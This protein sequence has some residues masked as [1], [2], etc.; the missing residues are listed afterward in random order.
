MTIDLV[1]NDDR[2][3]LALKRLS[4]H[5]TGL[6]QR[7]FRSIDQQ[8]HAVH[9]GQR[10]LHFP[11]KVS[12]AR[13]INDINRHITIANRRVLRHDGDAALPF[14]INIV[15]GA[16]SHLLVRPEYSTLMEQGVDKRRL[17]VVNVSN[18]CHVAALGLNDGNQGVRC[19]S[20]NGVVTLVL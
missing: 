16:H 9:H 10:A 20:H 13:C 6:R 8:Q 1:H 5:K 14:K 7:P 11:T 19:R 17:A 12:V 3:Q 2:C 18:D 4:Q 15:E